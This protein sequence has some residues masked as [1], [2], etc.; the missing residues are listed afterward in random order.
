MLIDSGQSLLSVMAYFATLHS[1][2]FINFASFLFYFL[3]SLVG[4]S[5]SLVY[6][7]HSCGQSARNGGEI[8]GR[9]TLAEIPY[10]MHRQSSMYYEVKA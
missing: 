9:L 4:S 1:G 8:K 3:F 10:F 5:P 6:H 2:F 7:L